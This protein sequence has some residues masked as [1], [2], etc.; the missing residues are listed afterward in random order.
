MKFFASIFVMVASL[1]VLTGCVEPPRRQATII[2]VVPIP[3]EI[4]K[5]TL[6]VGKTTRDDV[7]AAIGLPK[8]VSTYSEYNSSAWSYTFDE[9]NLII[10]I[11]LTGKDGYTNHVQFDLRKNL[12]HFS[13][14]FKGNILSDAS[15]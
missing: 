15:L 8:S 11:S 1:F 2:E 7:E 3:P 14:S 4:K 12:E 5:L 10:D 13:F 6:V 9:Q